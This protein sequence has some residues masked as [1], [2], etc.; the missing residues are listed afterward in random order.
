M[1]LRRLSWLKGSFINEDARTQ[2]A[3]VAYRDA[4]GSAFAYAHTNVP[5][6]NITSAVIKMSGMVCSLICGTVF[7]VTLQSLECGSF[8]N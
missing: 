5:L 8:L 6:E 7:T 2:T 4:N 1:R 3:S